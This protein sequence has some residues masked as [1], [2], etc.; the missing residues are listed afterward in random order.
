MWRE[1]V[2]WTF[3]QHDR[4][5]NY[6]FISTPYFGTQIYNVDLKDAKTN[7]RHC[8]AAARWYHLGGFQW[9]DKGIPKS[10]KPTVFYFLIHII[11]LFSIYTR[12][13]TTTSHS[14]AHIS[15]LRCSYGT[16]L[17]W[18]VLVSGPK[19]SDVAIT[20]LWVIRSRYLNH[21]TFNNCFLSG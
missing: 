8:A 2:E 4:L 21:I 18:S 10:R 9:T 5:V 11:L 15:K 12:T 1:N 7:A 14:F 19:F 20:T 3:H 16:C 17:R 13:N 6:K